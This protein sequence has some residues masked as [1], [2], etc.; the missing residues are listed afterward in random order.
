MDHEYD[1]RFGQPIVLDGC[2]VF[3][4]IRKKDSPKIS[5]LVAVDGISCIKYRGSDLGA[6]YASFNVPLKSDPFRIKAFVRNEEIA[7]EI[8]RHFLQDGYE[9][10]DSRVTLPSTTGKKRFGIWEAKL[11]A[12]EDELRLEQQVEKINLLL[13]KDRSINGRIFTFGRSLN[14]YKEVGYPS[15]VSTL[16][17]LNKEVERADI[18]I[19]HTRQ[20][21]NS[22]GAFPIWSHPF[23]SGE[24]AIV[25][26]GD[27]S[28]FGANIEQLNSWGLKS[29][30]GTDSEVVARLLA[31]LVRVEGLSIVE[32]AMVLTNP[33]ER[34]LSSSESLAL[35][36]KYKGARLDGPFVVVAGYCHKGDAYL[37]ALTDRSKFR[38]IIIGEDENNFYVASEESQIRNLSRNARVW[39]PDPGSFFIAS[40][41]S[42]IISKATTRDALPMES[43]LH[44][45]SEGALSRQSGSTLDATAK[46]FEEINEFLQQ[47]ISKGLDEV[48]ITGI[49]GQRYIGIGIRPKRSFKMVVCGFPGNCLA[50]LNSGAA[51][52]VFGNVA[53]DLGDTMHDGL[54]LVHGSARDVVGQTLQGGRIVIRGSVGNRAG[55]QMR[56]FGSRRP[57]LIVGETADDYLGEY[58]AGGVIVVLNLSGSPRPIGNY[59]GTGMVGGSIFIRGTVKESQLALLPQREDVLN[60]LR[61][62]V[63]DGDIPEETY[64]E[65]SKL[66]YPSEQALGSLLPEDLSSRI[67]F[68][69][70]SGKY[71]KTISMEYRKL[72]KVDQFLLAES[73]GEFCSV[74]GLSQMREELLASDY[75]VIRTK[76]EKAETPIPPQ[77]IPVEE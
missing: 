6:G 46:G 21:T 56:E 37:I 35:L 30:V 24:C 43:V 54:I 70:F 63:A 4:I 14:V 23:A 27:I 31:R 2:G 1:G 72:T 71:N 42:G 34:N 15:E 22:P 65:I 41:N 17:G 67:R 36:R 51:F 16:F 74:F 32:A 59:V 13:L 10:L 26:N 60:Y 57:Y 50:N 49:A 61:A 19:A 33:F 55:I 52:E 64:D 62:S 75:T 7:R 18:W 28:S 47:S 77:E 58:M 53:D 29:H 66:E 76:E 12:E 8:E 5:N 45:V 73:V 69:Y 44:T 40:V 11:R 48:S 9:L 39:T 25:H 68:L 38:P 3:G 20:P